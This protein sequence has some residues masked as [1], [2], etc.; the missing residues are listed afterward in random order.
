MKVLIFLSLL[1]FSH[2]VLAQEP[3]KVYAK[4]AIL[5]PGDKLDFEGISVKFKALISDSRCP[6]GVTCIW[7]GEAKVLVELFKGG[8][9]LGEEVVTIAPA[10]AAKYL[11]NNL[12]EKSAFS[13]AALALYPYPEIDSK[14]K[15]SEYRLKIRGEKVL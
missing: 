10:T 6:R 8:K 13:F 15:P 9:S 3:V 7:A 5:M 4:N 12:L 14:I 2:N 11:F 1:F